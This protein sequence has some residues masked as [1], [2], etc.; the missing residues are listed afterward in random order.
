MTAPVG[1]LVAG[2]IV[3][4]GLWAIEALSV[5]LHSGCIFPG[6]Y[7]P[8]LPVVEVSVHADDFAG[9]ERVAARLDLA[10]EAQDAVTGSPDKLRRYWSGWVSSAPGESLVWARVVA[11]EP[12]ADHPTPTGPDAR[13]GWESVP[14]FG[15]GSDTAD[16]SADEPVKATA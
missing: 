12:L 2:I 8:S 1:N 5:D 4:D 15:D 10:P 6:G 14:L 11:F 7:A 16:E 3:L 9:A 13:D